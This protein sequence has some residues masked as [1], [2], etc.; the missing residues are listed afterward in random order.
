MTKIIHI[1]LFEDV[2]ASALQ[3]GISYFEAVEDKKQYADVMAELTQEEEDK[4]KEKEK[5]RKEVYGLKHRP[6]EALNATPPAS[7]P[8]TLVLGL[9]SAS[10]KASRLFATNTITS[11]SRAS[12]ATM[13]IIAS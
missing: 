6:S 11:P 8:L 10:C 2:M 4:D 13:A 3:R 9:A 1:K 7:Q 12:A 5:R